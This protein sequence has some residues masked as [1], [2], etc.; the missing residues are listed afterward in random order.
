VKAAPGPA[1][2]ALVA[3]DVRQPDHISQSRFHMATLAFHR[4]KQLDDGARPRVDDGDHR[5]WRVAILE[6]EASRVSWYLE[7]KSL[8]PGAGLS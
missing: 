2:V 4:A 3:P 8:T 1:G 7:A 5:S 6:V